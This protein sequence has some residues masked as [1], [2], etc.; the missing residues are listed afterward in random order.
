V[1]THGRGMR[2]FTE[3]LMVAGC[4]AVIVIK[5]PYDVSGSQV[6]FLVYVQTVYQRCTIISL[7]ACTLNI[8]LLDIY[9]FPLKTTAGLS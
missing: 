2:Q 7:K 8:R 9:S 4:I 5:I 1:R 3:K 6:V